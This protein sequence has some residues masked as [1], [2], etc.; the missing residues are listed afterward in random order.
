MQRDR[1]RG[2]IR[3]SD[4]AKDRELL[5]RLG[6][7]VLD[8]QTE[9]G[10]VGFEDVRRYS[11]LVAPELSP[12]ATARRLR[13]ILGR[14][15]SEEEAR[16]AWDEIL[17]YKLKRLRETGE[18]VPIEQAAR[19]WDQKYGFGF[20]RRWYLTRPEPGEKRYVPGAH[21]RSPG[22]VAR[23]AGRILPELKP[24]LEAGF[25]VS[26]ILTIAARNPLQSARLVLRKVPRRERDRH[27]VQLVA[28]ITGWT[29]PPEQAEKVW[30]E[31][32]RHKLYVKEHLGQDI[33]MERAVVDYVKRL[34]LSGLDRAALWETGRLFPTR[35]ES[36]E[37]EEA[38]TP[39]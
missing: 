3:A 8:V 29:L 25:S 23:I 18:N 4:V 2:N 13:D 22:A 39:G 17:R 21:E 28:D 34:R 1:V 38:S 37:E 12:R 6:Y 10:D 31:A 32:L 9:S 14:P 36:P 33:S 24:L 30:E 16:A 27:Y 11:Y 15:F 35:E 5:N 7:G 19:E 20:R 26:D